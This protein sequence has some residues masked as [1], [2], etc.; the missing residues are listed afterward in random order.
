[1]C[2]RR[3]SRIIFVDNINYYIL[4]E[5]DICIVYSIVTE[6]HTNN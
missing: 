5:Y 4:H 1:M 2:A 6:E 3:G